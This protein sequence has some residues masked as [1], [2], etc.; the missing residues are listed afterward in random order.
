M[1]KKKQIMTAALLSVFCMSVTGCSLYQGNKD[2]QP[3]N[4]SQAETDTKEDIKQQPSGESE[5]ETKKPTDAHPEDIEPFPHGEKRNA[6][7]AYEK[8]KAHCPYDGYTLSG[9]FSYRQRGRISV[10]GGT[11]GRKADQLCVGD[12]RC[13]FLNRQKC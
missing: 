1:K 9:R 10:H 6:G 7:T 11:W 3:V 5:E 12:H 8:W 4:A 2:R 13:S